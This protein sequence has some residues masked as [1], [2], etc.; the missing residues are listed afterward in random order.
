L[1]APSFLE[2]ADPGQAS[3]RR[4]DLVALAACA[5]F[6]WLLAFLPH[7][8][9]WSRLGEP[10][11]FADSDD[12]EYMSV[13]AQAYFNHPTWL[14]DPTIAASDRSMYPASQFVPA[15]V[16]TRVLGL[17]PLGVDQIWRSWAG[18]S[19]GIG[20]Y[21]VVRLLVTRPRNAAAVA[22]V[23]LA[24]VGTMS[25][26]PIWGQ[27][28][29]FWQLFAG[30]GSALF[31]GYPRLLTQYRLIT[32]G[33]SLWAL[34]VHV[35]LVARARERPTWLRVVVAGASFGLLFYVYFYFWTAAGLALVLALIFDAG[36]RRVYF[37]VGCLGGL[38]GAPA[39]VSNYLMTRD[40]PKDWL[41]RTD[42]FLPISRFSELLFP[43]AALVV[44]AVVLIWSRSRHRTLFHLACLFAAGLILLNHQVV[45]G[46]QIQNFH[47]SYVW[48]PSGSL[49]ILLMAARVL[50]PG[51]GRR[52]GMKALVAI[53][54]VLHLAGGCWLRVAEA[55]QTRETREILADYV[56][57]R[58]Q[59]LVPEA[60]K[61]PAN[62]VVAGAPTFTK[63]AIAL[64]NVRPLAQYC[65][66]FSPS[67]TDVELGERQAL[68]AVLGGES[69]EAFEARHARELAEGWGSWQRDLTRRAAR[70]AELMHAFDAAAADPS[71][72]LDRFGVRA[73]A[74]SD[75]SPPPGATWKLLQ[76]GPAWRLWE[77]PLAPSR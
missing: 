47:W 32:P 52:P 37:L 65:T 54:C 3:W 22:A 2:L 25:C 74:R 45:T 38:I 51:V 53:S 28:R 4:G 58:A 6:G 18:L 33:L 31:D 42:T 9:W 39:V 24:D 60:P 12:V 57:F 5:G 36:H 55:T 13:S 1:T 73:V 10:V 41:L 43:R 19:L 67:I 15:V 61:L 16:L 63:L 29:T 21:L 68:D 34:L 77:R 76:D 66:L 64:E 20:F 75:S 23:L 27:C 11:Y 17:T 46:L 14:G 8:I 7:L 72:G 59:R 49:L 56:R 50:G 48:G 26:T 69:R 70:L 44:C 62:A 30:R 71:T 35:W 40:F